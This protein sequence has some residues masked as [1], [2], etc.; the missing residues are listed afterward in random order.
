M[1]ST[2]V[3]L[4]RSPCGPQVYYSSFEGEGTPRNCPVP[5]IFCLQNIIFK[6]TSVSPA[7]A[8]EGS[9][10][11]YLIREGPSPIPLLRI[12]TLCSLFDSLV[13]S[14]FVRIFFLPL[15]L[16]FFFFF[17]FSCLSRPYGFSLP[18]L[19]F[20]LLSLFRPKSDLR[21]FMILVP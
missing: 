12:K 20:R 17:V 16:F 13:R 3:C 19:L 9:Q 15:S 8:I 1:V 11:A 4:A 10:V 21:R 14:G 7:L 6:K 5:G 2:V 18:S